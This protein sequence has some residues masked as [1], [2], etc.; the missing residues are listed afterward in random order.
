MSENETCKVADLGQMIELPQ[1]GEQSHIITD[2]SKIP[3]RWCSP[4]YLK[5]KKCSVASDVWS[6]GV[7]MWEMANPGRVP[8]RNYNN[9]EAM[10]EIRGGHTLEIPSCYPKNVQNIMTS[11]WSFEPEKRPSFLYIFMHLNRVN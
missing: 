2:T 11:C 1:K 4:E 3:V 8:Y 7:V 5:E 10:R 6:F 9:R